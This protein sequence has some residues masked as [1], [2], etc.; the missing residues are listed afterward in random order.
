M[1][2]RPQ[3]V[4]LSQWS[5]FL[6]VIVLGIVLIPSFGAAGALIADGVA[7]VMAGA[8]MFGFLLKKIPRKYQ[9]SLLD[10]TWRFLCI[11][12]LAGLPALFWHPVDRVWLC[13]SG[14]LFVGLCVI[15]LRMIR[16]L[17]EEDVALLAIYSPRSTR[18]LRWFMRKG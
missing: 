4:V 9:L 13:V 3:F 18:Y 1:L 8:L 7:R 15:L 14:C 17:N 5:G 6:L 16:P 12:A 11:L 10:F 2:G